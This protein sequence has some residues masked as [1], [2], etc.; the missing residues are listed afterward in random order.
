MTHIDLTAYDTDKSSEYLENYEREFGELF[1]KDI[2]LLELGIQRG[3]SMRLWLDLLPNAKIAGLDLNEIDVEDNTGRLH[4]YQ[5]FQQ[6]PVTLDRI[7]ADVSPAGFDVIIDDASH[8]GRYTSESFWH[9]FPRHLKSGGVYVIDDWGCG[10]WSDWTDG[11]AYVGSRTVLGELETSPVK[12]SSSPGRA[13]DLRR[14]I[15]ASARPIAAKLSPETRKHLEKLYM[16]VEGA[17]VQRRFKSHDYGMVGFIKQL[18]DAT[19]VQNIDRGAG[20][21]LD[22]GIASVNVYASQVFVHKR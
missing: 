16:R 19:S 10:Y 20:A 3:G 8:I 14:K 21:T 17:S 22:N 15:R 4:I 5:G 18:V 9:L 13:E 12:P 11:H 2:S 1:D 6:D 7:A